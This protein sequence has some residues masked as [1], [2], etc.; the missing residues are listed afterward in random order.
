M[1]AGFSTQSSAERLSGAFPHGSLGT[2]E[3]GRVSGCWGSWRADPCLYQEG[4]SHPD[5]EAIP[6]GTVGALE[7]L[8]FVAAGF[9]MISA[10]G[11]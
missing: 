5:V 7:G 4:L 10:Q 2:G 11:E 6:L 1:D 9:S 8:C 3:L